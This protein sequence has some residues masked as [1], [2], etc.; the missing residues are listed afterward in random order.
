MWGARGSG[1]V[2]LQVVTFTP[3]KVIASA[4]SDF[5]RLIGHGPQSFQTRLSVKRG[6]FIALL[7]CAGGRIARTDGE[8]DVDLR[9][10]NGLLVG[11]S[12]DRSLMQSEGAEYAFNATID[13]SQTATS[14]RATP[15]PC[16]TG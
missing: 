15:G 6:D 2:A 16:P 13:T 1:R 12:R 4:Q 7:V 5:E 14:A 9:W 11:Q 10:D 3:T 8:G